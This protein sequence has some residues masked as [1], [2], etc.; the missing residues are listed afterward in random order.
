[1]W[2]TVVNRLYW[3]NITYAEGATVSNGDG[4]H[5]VTFHDGVGN[6]T[7]RNIAWADVAATLTLEE[8]AECEDV[9]LWDKLEH[10]SLIN[11]AKKMWGI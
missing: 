10:N 4:T 6:V 8:L 2:R 5:N 7:I 9:V 1:M 3:E 11:Y